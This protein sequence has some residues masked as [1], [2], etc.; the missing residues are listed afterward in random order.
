MAG[1]TALMSQG[2]NFWV[3]NLFLG[4]SA[5]SIPSKH[6]NSRARAAFG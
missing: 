1:G 3:I 4:I 2:V 5:P 6:L